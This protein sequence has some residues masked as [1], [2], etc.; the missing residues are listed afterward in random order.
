MEVVKQRSSSYPPLI[1][2]Q[3]MAEW[4]ASSSCY[5]LVCRKSCNTGGRRVATKF[6]VLQELGATTRRIKTRG[7]RYVGGNNRW[8][9]KKI[10]VWRAT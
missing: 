3:A 2:W 8:G 7:G 5:Q 9:E 4:P 6:G 10:I 1:T